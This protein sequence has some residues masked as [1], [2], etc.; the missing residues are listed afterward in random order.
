MHKTLNRFI[1]FCNFVITV[2]ICTKLFTFCVNIMMYTDLPVLN[3]RSKK[4]D[5]DL[6]ETV[7]IVEI[8]SMCKICIQ[9]EYCLDGSMS[10]LHGG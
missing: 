2:R 3:F 9:K 5:N 4:S 6:S 7:L 1:D 10:G 8:S